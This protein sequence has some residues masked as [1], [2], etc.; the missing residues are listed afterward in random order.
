MG[1]EAVERLTRGIPAGVDNFNEAIQVVATL[2]PLYSTQEHK[3]GWMKKAAL[4]ERTIIRRPPSAFTCPAGTMSEVLRDLQRAGYVE[5]KGA[6]YTLAHGAPAPFPEQT[7]PGW[8]KVEGIGT[9]RGDER[10][11]ALVVAGRDGKTAIATNV[12][13]N[14]GRVHLLGEEERAGGGYEKYSTTVMTRQA[15][16]VEDLNVARA[17]SLGFEVVEKTPSMWE[18]F[19]S[20]YAVTRDASKL[21][22][23]AKFYSDVSYQKVAP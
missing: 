22:V 12:W 14:H 6:L 2:R 21:G 15:A 3:R 7:F 13:G 17:K 19:G 11:E 10:F 1:R 23:L 5:R 16:G 9:V 20:F 8:V 18:R 4:C